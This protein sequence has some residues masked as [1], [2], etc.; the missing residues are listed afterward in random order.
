LGTAPRAIGHR[1]QPEY[2]H[3]CVVNLSL[4]VQVAQASDEPS[5][6]EDWSRSFRF[7][8]ELLDP[9]LHATQF[10]FATLKFLIQDSYRVNKPAYS[11]VWFI[12]RVTMDDRDLNT[13]RI[14][15]S[16]AR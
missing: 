5:R 2:L 4:A 7:V 9:L 14:E 3:P 11:V 13:L 16:G 10:R 15:I 8:A 6:E 1:I 12:K